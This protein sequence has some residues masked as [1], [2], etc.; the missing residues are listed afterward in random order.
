MSDQHKAALAAGREEGRAIRRYLDALESHKPKRGRKR[1]P[2]GI[3]RRLAE[4]DKRT[5]TADPLTRVQLVQERMDLERHLQALSAPTAD[6]A[7]LETA[8]VR[9]A[10]NYSSRK[11]ITYAAW[12]EIGVPPAVLKRANITRSA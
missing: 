11:G 1:T 10:K 7:K 2:D 4:I 3:R 9:A 8:F 5:A 12:R 6:V